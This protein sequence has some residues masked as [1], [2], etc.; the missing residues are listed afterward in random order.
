[1]KKTEIDE[2]NIHEGKKGGK[3]TNQG[4]GDQQENQKTQDIERFMQ[5]IEECPEL[6]D[7]LISNILPVSK[8]SALIIIFV[9]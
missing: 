4:K 1:M 3:K 5:D 8:R 9:L 7:K 2:N 6:K